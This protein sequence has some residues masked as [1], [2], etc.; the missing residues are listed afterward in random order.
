MMNSAYVIWYFFAHLHKY[1]LASGQKINSYYQLFEDE[2]RKVSY[3]TTI[4]RVKCVC[5][6]VRI[7]ILFCLNIFA[8]IHFSFVFSLFETISISMI[9]IASLISTIRSSICDWIKRPRCSTHFRSWIYL[10][11]EERR[12][13][14][15]KIIYIEA[16]YP[17]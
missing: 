14:Q 12:Q 3:P 10:V 13:L 1:S 5:Y 16:Y 11:Q 6:A 15:L 8:Y 7:W 9:H 2:K 17:S 4:F